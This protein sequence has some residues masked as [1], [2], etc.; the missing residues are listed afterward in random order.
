MSILER[1]E[2]FK[3][4]TSRK[5]RKDKVCYLQ[6]EDEYVYAPVVDMGQQ[7]VVKLFQNVY[8]TEYSK[9]YMAYVVNTKYGLYRY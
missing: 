3:K 5:S 6:R 1:L 4:H 7:K 2:A 9:K 8:K